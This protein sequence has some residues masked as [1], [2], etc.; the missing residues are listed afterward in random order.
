MSSKNSAQSHRN[1]RS[2]NSGSL[3]LFPVAMIEYPDKQLKGERAYC[4]SHFRCI[5]SVVHEVAQ[6]SYSGRGKKL[7]QLELCRCWT[8]HNHS[9]EAEGGRCTL[10]LPN[11]L[12]WL[13]SVGSHAVPPIVNRLCQCHQNNPPQAISEANPPPPDGSRFH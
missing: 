13:C 10:L 9:E 3:S 5:R 2:S 11:S 7:R 6:E 4:I 1:G 12:V 8:Q